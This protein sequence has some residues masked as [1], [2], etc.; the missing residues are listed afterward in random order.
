M[1][2][3][4]FGLAV[5]ALAS[6]PTSARADEDFSYHP[7]GDLTPGS[8]TGLFDETVYAPGMRFPIENGPAY[9]NSQVWGHGGAYGPGGGQC[10]AANYSY[11]WRD[12]YCE[13]RSWDMPLCPSGTGHQGQDIRPA[14]CEDRAHWIVSSEAGTVT[15][16]GSYSVYVTAPSGQRFDYLHG[17]DVQVASGQAV[18]KGQ[19][20]AT[21]SNAFGG[22][23]TTIHLHYNIRQDVAGVGFV[24]VNPYMSLVKSYEELMGLGSE[25]PRGPIDAATCESIRGW[26]QDPDDPQTPVEVR[27]YFGGEAS[28][29][30][31]VGVS[32][33]AD[34]HRDDLCE[35]LGSCAHGF[36]LE[37]P[38]SLFDGQPHEV[39]AYGVDT[40]GA[41]LA[42]LE[43]SP[44]VVMCE[45]GPLPSGVRRAVGGPDALADWGLSPFW[46]GAPVSTTALE[47]IPQGESWPDRRRVVRAEGDTDWWWVDQGRRRLVSPHAAAVWGIEASDVMVRPVEEIEAAPLGPP[48]R[49]DKLVVS[50][51]GAALW[52]IDD[53]VC[54]AGDDECDDGG[55]DAGTGTGGDDSDSGAA[56]E[57][58][59]TVGVLPGA[60]DDSGEGCGCRT[61]KPAKKALPVALWLLAAARRR[62]RRSCEQSG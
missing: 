2:R 28:D 11:P 15:N 8:G 48:L 32:I 5:V 23:P 54:P 25:P 57:G 27:V 10:E 4:V 41:E 26:A 9:P 33:L 6:V 16:V 30:S 55:S 42:E 56:T 3:L 13:S 35:P 19:R 22:T 47:A 49:S 39:F 50:A 21:V 24:Y 29:P 12:N 37:V 1:K 40:D 18:D 58:T 60:D 38:R 7:P 20:L 62:R 44:G 45:L 31:A 52:V 46:D 53:A 34:E 36:T 17:R 51:D 14:T 59:A 43:A 61:T